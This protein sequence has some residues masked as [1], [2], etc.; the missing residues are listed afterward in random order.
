M[1]NNISISLFYNIFN[2]MWCDLKK[3]VKIVKIVKI[4]HCQVAPPKSKVILGTMV[5]SFYEWSDSKLSHNYIPSLMGYAHARNWF[6]ISWRNQG[7]FTNIK[8]YNILLYNAEA[9]FCIKF[10]FHFKRFRTSFKVTAFVNNAYR[11]SWVNKTIRV[12]ATNLKSADKFSWRSNGTKQLV[13][14]SHLR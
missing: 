6:R 14:L 2:S 7:S 5:I 4:I 10:T 1:S 13:G 9:L 11:S 8:R 3:I 12:P